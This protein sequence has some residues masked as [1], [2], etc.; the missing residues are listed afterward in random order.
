M[1]RLPYL[2]IALTIFLWPGAPQWFAYIMLAVNIAAASGSAG[3]CTPGWKAMLGKIIHPNRRGLLFSLG[4]GLGGFLGIGGAL[5]ARYVLNTL[6]YP[7]SYGLCFL[8]S[9]LFQ[10]ISWLFLVLN[11]EPARKPEISSP[12]AAHY[13]RELF[14]FLRQNPNFSWYLAGSVLVIFGSMAASFYII[15]AKHA[16]QIADGFAASLTMA[17]LITQS[18][19][20]PALGWLSDRK[21]HK[22]LNELSILFMASSLILML[23]IPSQVWMYPAFILMNL[24]I[25]GVHISRASITM[26]FG[27]IDRLPTY[28]ALSGTILGVP[29][30]LAPVLGGWMLDLFG[31]NILFVAALVLSLAGWAVIRLRVRDPRVYRH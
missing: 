14:P 19:G 6:E 2:F 8:L 3:L 28:T 11:R 5:L 30:L 22:W 17:A 13:F 10:A 21:G 25:A 31:Y 15:R 7:L 12:S 24:S 18:V 27:G 4:V 26:E 23:F 16:F 20:T 1:E 9:F 29:T